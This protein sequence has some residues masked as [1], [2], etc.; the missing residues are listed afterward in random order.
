MNKLTNNEQYVLQVI[1]DNQ[2]VQDDE[3]KLL[4]A[5]WLKQGFDQTKSLYWNLTRVMHAETAA[6]ARRKLHELGLI[7]YSPTA[8]RRRTKRYKAEVERHSSYEDRVAQIVRPRIELV[9]GEW[10]TTL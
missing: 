10:V 9:N 7:E 1:K 2:G 6:R 5:I 4:E 3:H 8:L